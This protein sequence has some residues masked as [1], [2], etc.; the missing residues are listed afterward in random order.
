MGKQRSR[1]G[2][3]V[4]KR[5]L[6]NYIRANGYVCPGLN[7]I[8]HPATQLEVDHVVPVALGGR[9]TDGLRVL[10]ATC[11]LSRGAK[12]GNELRARKPL[13]TSRDW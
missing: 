12:L 1:K 6:E 4:R 5:F 2:W 13:R 11:N 3:Q 10:C 7:G 9:D 8:A